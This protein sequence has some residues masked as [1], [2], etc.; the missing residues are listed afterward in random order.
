[1]PHGDYASVVPLDPTMR[2][3]DA[4]SRLS[5]NSLY[6]LNTFNVVLKGFFSGTAGCSVVSFPMFMFAFIDHVLGKSNAFCNAAST[7][8][9]MFM[10]CRLAPKPSSSTAVHTWN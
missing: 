4:L 1:M 2:N 9:N 8:G 3:A 7:P 5:Y 10:C 6:D